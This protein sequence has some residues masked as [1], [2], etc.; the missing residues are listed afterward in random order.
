MQD[1]YMQ[2]H[3]KMNIHWKATWSGSDEYADGRAA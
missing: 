2:E 1:K 3:E